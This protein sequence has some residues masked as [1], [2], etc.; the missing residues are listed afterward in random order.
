MSAYAS[1]A[2]T[3]ATIYPLAAIDVVVYDSTPGDAA[4]KV[5]HFAL[6]ISTG[7]ARVQ[8]YVT[9]DEAQALIATLRAAVERLQVPA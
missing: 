9:R 8:G 1:P 2:V 6:V 3:C 5:P 4:T 7:A